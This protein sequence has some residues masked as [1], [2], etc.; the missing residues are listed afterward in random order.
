MH[1]GEVL[2]TARPL[3]KLVLN[4]IPEMKFF[5]KEKRIVCL[6]CQAKG[7]SLGFCLKKPCVFTPKNLRVL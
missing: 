3:C 5:V 2:P 1:W 6:L 7:D 4:Q